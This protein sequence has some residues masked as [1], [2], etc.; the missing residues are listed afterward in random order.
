MC[1]DVPCHDML[2]KVFCLKM[3]SGRLSMRVRS[4]LGEERKSVADVVKWR[5]LN[6]GGVFQLFCDDDDPSET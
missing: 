1:Y 2:L 4:V 6:G 3:L 5:W